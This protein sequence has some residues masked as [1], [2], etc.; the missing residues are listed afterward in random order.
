MR[1]RT[2]YQIV[3][4][5][6]IVNTLVLCY[7]YWAA[8]V[9]PYSEETWVTPFFT[10][11][12]ESD[13]SLRITKMR[14]V[15]VVYLPLATLILYADIVHESILR[16]CGRDVD[17]S[18]VG[19]ED[20]IIAA[21]HTERFDPSRAYVITGGHFPDFY[22]RNL[23]IFYSSLLDRRIPTNEDDWANRQRITL[24]TLATHLELLRVAGKEYTTFAPVGPQAFAAINWNDEPSDSL[25]AITYTLRA[26]TDDC[27]IFRRLPALHLDGGASVH[28]LVTQK[29]AKGLLD[30]YRPTIEKELARYLALVMDPQTG[31]VKKEAALSGARDNVRQISGYYDNMIAYA[32]AKDAAA[33]GLSFP[34]PAKYPSSS[35]CDFAQWKKNIISAFWREEDSESGLFIDDLSLKSLKEKTFTGEAFLALSTG[36]LDIS[37]AADRAILFKMVRY[38]KS[39][40]LDVPFPLLYA[41]SDDKSKASNFFVGFSSYAGHSIWSHLGQAYIQ[42]LIFLSPEHPELYADIQSHLGKYKK[43]IEIYGGYPELY[44]ADGTLFSAPVSRAVLRVGWVIHYEQTKMLSRAMHR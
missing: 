37:E 35:S 39:H 31:L 42:T 40:G 7:D 6:V 9:N 2:I 8:L 19:N 29:A 32:T 20:Q 28:R 27:F 15:Q 18:I 14:D 4:I 41:A 26:A 36:F 34:C 21:L 16:F 1:Y 38:V 24:Q 43:N 25:F 3:A 33:L 10:T 23:G 17:G 30:E 22:V 13:G 5:A 44:N 12:I 11:S